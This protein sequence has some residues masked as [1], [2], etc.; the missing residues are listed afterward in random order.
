MERNTEEFTAYLRTF[1]TPS[2]TLTKTICKLNDKAIREAYRGDENFTVSILLFVPRLVYGV[3][4]YIMMRWNG[5]SPPG[6]NRGPS[7][8]AKQHI[9][10]VLYYQLASLARHRENR[11]TPLD[12]LDPQF[13]NI[14]N[15]LLGLGDNDGDHKAT[16]KLSKEYLKWLQTTHQGFYECQW[17]TI[18]LLSNSTLEIRAITVEETEK[19]RHTTTFF[20]P[21][22][23]KKT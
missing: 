11:D 17:G 9:S 20:V 22:H 23:Q 8:D 3:S 4:L 19:P 1:F 12:L 18:R 7:V 21:Y 10:E 5:G 2:D 13:L 15:Q 16:L 6:L 14:M